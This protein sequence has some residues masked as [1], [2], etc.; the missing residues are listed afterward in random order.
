MSY[1]IASAALIPA[2]LIAWLEFTVSG[3]VAGKLG[4]DDHRTRSLKLKL[5]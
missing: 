4:N 1:N 5:R 2:I 3:P